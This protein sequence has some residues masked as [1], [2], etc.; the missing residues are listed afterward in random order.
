MS[1]ELKEIQQTLTNQASKSNQ[2]F[3]EKMVPGKQ[4]VY[5]VKTLVLNELVKRYKAGSFALAEELWRS[6]WLEERI[7]AIKI[8]EKKGKEDPVRLLKLFKNFS[9]DI[10]NWAVCD[11]LGMQFL[12]GIVKTHPAE[13]FAIAGKFNRSKFFWQRRLSLVMVEW[14][15]RTDQFKPEIKKLARQLEKDDEYYV[16]KAVVWIN[17]NFVKG[18]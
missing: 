15:T 14:Y 7:I 12:R 9:K 16:K 13:I 18:K 1:K 2:A 5:G 17:R 8:M 6:G 4:K 10:D 11:G 3:F